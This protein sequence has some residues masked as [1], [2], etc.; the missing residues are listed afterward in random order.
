MYEWAKKFNFR[1]RKNNLLSRKAV[2]VV[3]IVTSKRWRQLQKEQQEWKLQKLSPCGH[4][5]IS[6]IKCAKFFIL[7]QI[8][9]FFLIFF[10]RSVLLHWLACFTPYVNMWMNGLISK[11]HLLGSSTASLRIALNPRA[12]QRSSR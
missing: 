10:P 12:I 11:L 6:K 2:W 8:Q 4:L 3:R 5:A 7:F 9:S 1:T